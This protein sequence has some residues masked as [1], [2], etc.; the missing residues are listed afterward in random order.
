MVFKAGQ[1]GNPAG[2]PTGTHR[3]IANAGK[4]ML[5]S[6]FCP[7]L[8]AMAMVDD[9]A[10]GNRER[11]ELLKMLA[12]KYAPNLKS[13]EHLGPL[14]TAFSINIVPLNTKNQQETENTNADK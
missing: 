11:A 12:D 4:I 2:R 6:G 13:I 9:K 3:A 8:R 5:D 14:G 10:V 1:S 7:I